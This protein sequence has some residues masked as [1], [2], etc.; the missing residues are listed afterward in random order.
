MSVAEENWLM[1]KVSLS[2]VDRRGQSKHKY[3]EFNPMDLMWRRSQD[4]SKDE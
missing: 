2:E 3:Q 1:L 4:D